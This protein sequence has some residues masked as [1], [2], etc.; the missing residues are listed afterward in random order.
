MGKTSTLVEPS[1]ASWPCPRDRAFNPENPEGPETLPDGL[2][3]SQRHGGPG[4]FPLIQEKE[5]LMRAWTQHRVPVWPFLLTL[6]V[7]HTLQNPLCGKH[8]TLLTVQWPSE[9]THEGTFQSPSAVV[10]D[11]VVIHHAVN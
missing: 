3:H 9:I 8:R 2:C 4:V 5:H 7:G 11:C 6:R 1:N 10:N